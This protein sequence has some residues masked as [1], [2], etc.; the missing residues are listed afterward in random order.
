MEFI[1]MDRLP[2][3]DDEMVDTEDD[4]VSLAPLRQKYRPFPRRPLAEI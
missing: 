3:L 2:E 4:D 1:L